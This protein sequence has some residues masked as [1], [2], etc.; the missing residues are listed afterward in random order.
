VPNQ[1][2]YAPPP[3]SPAAT[4][5][6]LGAI[7]VL[8]ACIAAAFAYVGGWF[9]PGRLTPDRVLAAIQEDGH[10]HPGFRRNHAKGVCAAGWFDSN[11]QAAA[12][13]KAAVFQTGHFPVIA[14]FSLAGSLPF[15]PDTPEQV[16]ALALRVMPPSGEEWRAAMINLPVFVANTVD[17][18]YALVTSAAPDPATGKPDPAKMQALF[19]AHPEIPRALGI[20]GQHKVGAG[21][22]DETF[23]SLDAFRFIGPDGAASAVRWSFVPVT[24]PLGGPA[25]P[26]AAPPPAAA[27]DKNY[28]FDGLIAAIAQHPRQ[29]HMIVTVAG[30][31]DVTADPTIAWPAGRRTVDAGTLTIDHIAA[32]ADGACD[33][34]VF[35]PLVLPDGITASDDPIPS[36]RSAAYG[37]SF[38]LRAGE[39]TIRQP[40]AVTPQEVAAGGKS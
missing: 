14:R 8:L 16:R 13:S 18:F 23:N 37:R 26:Q 34:V 19:A 33:P 36:A 30:P 24:A 11:G 3:L 6:R 21:F 32:E 9:S 25:A 40:S 38:T 27:G 15:Q 28:L 17:G 5:V 1:N 31:G 20:V 12:L 4:L 39:Q 2:G 29:W 35:D 7:G 10:M 22:D